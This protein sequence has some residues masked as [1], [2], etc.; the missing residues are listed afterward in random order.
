MINAYGAEYYAE[1]KMQEDEARQG[2]PE[3]EEA[4]KDIKKA[5]EAHDTET[6]LTFIESALDELNAFKEKQEKIDRDNYANE[7][8][9]LITASYRW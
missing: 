3:A 5:L 8:Q 2:I 6:A 1:S 7:M 4:I 9:D